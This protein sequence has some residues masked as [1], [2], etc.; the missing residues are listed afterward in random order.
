MV[1]DA[2]GAVQG[3]TVQDGAMRAARADGASGARGAGRRGQAKMCGCGGQVCPAGRAA[4]ESRERPWE[5]VACLH[6]I[7]NCTAFMLKS[8]LAMWKNGFHNADFGRETRQLA[9]RYP[10]WSRKSE[11]QNGNCI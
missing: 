5:T 6:N 2:R 3:G 8:L 11:Q 1:R 9:R 7:V 10:Y 4:A